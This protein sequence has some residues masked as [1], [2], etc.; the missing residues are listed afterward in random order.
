[1]CG[2]W[3]PI[4][5]Q[6][7]P[8]TSPFTTNGFARFTLP[9]TFLRAGG[10]L[11]LLS[12]DAYRP[13]TREWLRLRVACTPCCM[14]ANPAHSEGSV[15]HQLVCNHHT[16]IIYLYSEGSV[17][18][19]LVCNHRTCLFEALNMPA[20]APA[21]MFLRPVVCVGWVGLR[22]VL[23]HGP[24]HRCPTRTCA[25]SRTQARACVTRRSLA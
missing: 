10:R 21:G 20:A 4:S 15:V 14:S 11:W 17:A 2:L 13:L 7:R 12:D 23:V 18:H 1:M 22:L 8:I 6:H 16:Y 3:Y 24:M 5:H 9:T 25:T 19:R